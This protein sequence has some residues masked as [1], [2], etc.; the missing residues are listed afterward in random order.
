MSTPER[1]PVTGQ[2]VTPGGGDPAWVPPEHPQTAQVTPWSPPWTGSPK[3]Y[4]LAAAGAAPAAATGVP[5]GTPP[6]A[7][8][9]E[10]VPAEPASG[11]AAA[12]AA[13]PEGTP[14]PQATAD[15]E[16]VSPSLAARRYGAGA[17]YGQSRG[18]T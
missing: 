2:F 4:Q 16:P 7:R 14:G 13:V 17:G 1:H 8:H 5:A 18:S 9:H 6:A 15:G 10:D 12:G 3:L 11:P